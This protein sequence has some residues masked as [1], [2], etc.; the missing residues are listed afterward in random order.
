MGSKVKKN[1][2]E[3]SPADILFHDVSFPFGLTIP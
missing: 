3:V 2:Q 1:P